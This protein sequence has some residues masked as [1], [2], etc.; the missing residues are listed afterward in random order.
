MLTNIL[1]GRMSSVSIV[2]H[3]QYDCNFILL[4]ICLKYRIKNYR[5]KVL[6]L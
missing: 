1:R 2:F 4:R 3:T 5:N 6:T